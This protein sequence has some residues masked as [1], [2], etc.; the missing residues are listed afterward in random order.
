MTHHMVDGVGLD[1]MARCRNAFLIR[2]PE[3][4][5]AS[6]AA[7]R[8]EVSF[9][10]IG[11]ARQAELFDREADRLGLAPPVIDAEDV[12][13]DPR[14]V[15]SA[16]CGAL[17]IPFTSAMLRWPAGRRA[18]DGVWAPVW[19]GAVERSTGFGR[20][21]ERPAR[22]GRAVATASPSARGRITG[23][24]RNIGLPRARRRPKVRNDNFRDRPMHACSRDASA[25]SPSSS[26]RW[27][28][29]GRP[30]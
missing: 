13:A 24:W 18:T 27:C 1:W 20:P 8:P 5:L 23:A 30:A 11:F 28:R 17:G 15:L 7:K 22:A 26:A 19:Y 25:R 3:R 6:Y 21:R 9:E 29:R 16:L 2:S 4:V 12:L 10:D 14:R